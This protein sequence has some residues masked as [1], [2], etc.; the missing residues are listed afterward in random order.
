VV[1]FYS[2][3]CRRKHSTTQFSLYATASRSNGQEIGKSLF[4]LII[5]F[6]NVNSF[7][8]RFNLNQ[9]VK[10]QRLVFWNFISRCVSPCS[11]TPVHCTWTSA[12]GF[13]TSVTS[14]RQRNTGKMF[15]RKANKSPIIRLHRLILYNRLGVKRSFSVV[16]KQTNIRKCVKACKSMAQRLVFSTKCHEGWS[17]AQSACDVL[18]VT[19]RAKPWSDSKRNVWT[20]VKPSRLFFCQTTP[21]RQACRPNQ[22]REKLV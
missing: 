13:A 3:N 22:Q 6:L 17:S 20:A 1:R 21:W 18:C 8:K 10:F 15:F 16:L 11:W 4:L 9:K 12:L 19:D 2:W 14:C 5:A 7:I